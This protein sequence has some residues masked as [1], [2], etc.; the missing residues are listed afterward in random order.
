MHSYMAHQTKSQIKSVR[1]DSYK[2]YS[3]D[4]F[5]VKITYHEVNMK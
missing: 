1:G 4:K 5:T 2:N 3:E